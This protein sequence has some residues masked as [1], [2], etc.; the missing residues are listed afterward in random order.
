MGY[1]MY[2]WNNLNIGWGIAKL[3]CIWD[4]LQCIGDLCNWWE[5]LA[6]TARRAASTEGK[7]PALRAIYVYMQGDSKRV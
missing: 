2:N 3:K 4:E 6:L 1:H 5:F 7:F